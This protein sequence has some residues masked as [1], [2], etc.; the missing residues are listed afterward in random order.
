MGVLCLFSCAHLTAR[1]RGSRADE[2]PSRR[3]AEQTSRRADEQLAVVALKFE[4]GRNGSF[5]EVVRMQYGRA[6]RLALEHLR[7]GSEEKVLEVLED[8]KLLWIICM[9]YIHDLSSNEWQSCKGCDSDA[10]HQVRQGD[11][12]RNLN[13][14]QLRHDSFRTT[15]TMLRKG[16]AE[17]SLGGIEIGWN[18]HP[19]GCRAGCLGVVFLADWGLVGLSGA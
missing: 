1:Q 16:V 18:Q 11:G 3:A 19:E 10:P 4:T 5:H 17:S 2:Q 12:P 14:V 6:L 8:D 7:S 13:A 15:R 9:S